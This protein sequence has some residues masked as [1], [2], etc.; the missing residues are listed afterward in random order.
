MLSRLSIRDIVL[1]EKLDIDFLPGLSVLTG[2]TGAGKSILLDA[3]SLALGARGD[4][5]LVRHGATQ[6]QVIAVF[7]VPRNHPA[8]ALLADNAIEDDGDIIL[9]RVQTADGRTRVFVND[10]PSSVTLMRDIGHALVEIHG[11]HDERAL[12]DPGAH[13]ELLDSFGGHLGA[14]RATGEAWR[15]WRGCEQDLAKHRAKVEAAAREADYLRASVA[16]LAKLDPQPGEE[17]ELAELRAMMMRAEKIASEIHDAQDVLSGP[18]SPLPQLASLLRRLQRKAGE[19][20]GLL[21]DVVKSL[22][23]AMLSLDAAQSGVE[24]ALRATEYDPQRLEKAEERLFALRAA[25]RKHSVAVDDLAQLRD[26]MAADLA[27]LDAGEER[28][29][30]LEKQAAAA[31]EAYDISAAQ[32]SSL[33]H[34]AAVGLTRAVMAELPALKL[35][36]AE[37]IVEIASDAES[38]MEEGIDQVEFWVRTNPGTRPGPMMKVASGG[39]LSRFLLALKV[40]LA[41][42]GSAPTLVFDE[43]DTGVGG[44]VADAIGQRLARLSKRVQVLSVTHAPQVAARAATHFLISKSGGTDRVATGIAEM[45]RPARQEEIARMLA[46]ATITDEARAAAE[47]LLRE[48]TAAA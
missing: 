16:E 25:S 26:T 9:R 24:A 17:S 47:R 6:G 11:Q 13:R 29:H 14:A 48:N 10:Q 33:R 3:L 37:F 22:D 27:D 2:E 5:A 12:V 8:R 23:E 28:L 36:R 32:L 41:D 46:G 45:D 31:R 42:R 19:A 1:I 34:A 4:A 7:D 44:A 38:R 15:Y 18:S 35:E 39:E 20:P 40:A 21:D 30:A 43:I